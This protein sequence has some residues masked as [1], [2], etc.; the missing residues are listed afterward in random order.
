MTEIPVQG[1]VDEMKQVDIVFIGEIHN[2]KAHHEIQLSLIRAL[3]QA[4]EKLAIGIEMFKAEDQ[5]SLDRWVSGEMGEEEFKKVYHRNWQVSWSQYKGIFMYAK[6]NKIPVIGLNVP[7]KVIHQVFKNGFDSL[8]PSELKELPPGLTC[9]VDAEYEEFIRSAMEEHGHM[10]DAS[11]KNFCEAQMV[12]D[13][14]MSQKAVEYLRENEDT[15]MVLLAGGGHSWKRGIP[16]QVSRRSDMS[17][18]VILPEV[19][20]K[21]NFESIT[22]KDTDYLW[23]D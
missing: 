20:D 10:E 6:E 8:G 3:H 18:I 21:I 7:R 23:V 5:D 16:A 9:D 13:A 11:F 12:W 2:E 19:S 17:Y 22:T 14:A 4:G 15:M 1:L